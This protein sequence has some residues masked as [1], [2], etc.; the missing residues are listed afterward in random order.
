MNKGDQIYFQTKHGPKSGHVHAVGKHGA[1]VE[2]DGKRHKVKHHHVLGVKASIDRKF[3]IVDKG[4]EGSLVEDDEG[5]RSYVAGD[6]PDAEGYLDKFTSLDSVDDGDLV[7]RRIEREMHGTRCYQVLNGQ[8]PAG[9]VYVGESAKR[10]VRLLG[11]LDTAGLAAPYEVVSRSMVEGDNEKH[12]ALFA[13]TPEEGQL[14]DFVNA[15]AVFQRKNS[16][17]TEDIM[18]IDQP[19]NG[20]SEAVLSSGAISGKTILILGEREGFDERPVYVSVD[21][22]NMMK[23]RTLDNS[24]VLFMK[25]G[26]IKNRAGLSL[27]DVTDKRGVTEKRW[28]R[29]SEPVKKERNHAQDGEPGHDDSGGGKELP[30]MKRGDSVGFQAGS[31]TGS[32]EIVASGKDGVTVKD[33]RGRERKIHY[34]EITDHK[35]QSPDYSEKEDGEK[36]WDKNKI[37]NKDELA[38]GKMAKQGDVRSMEDLFVQAREALPMYKSF[39]SNIASKEGWL[40]FD[41]DYDNAV[42]AYSKP[43]SGVL[44]LIAGLKGEDRV[45]EKEKTEEDSW[46]GLKDIVRG[47]IAV[48]SLSDLPKVMDL[49]RNSGM[50]LARKPKNKFAKP[51]EHG[52]RDLN[53]NIITSNGHIA[54][55]QVNTKAM[56]LAKEDAHNHYEEIRTLEETADEEDRPLTSSESVKWKE[57]NDKSIAIY[58]KAWDSH[59]DEHSGKSS[60]KELKKAILFIVEKGGRK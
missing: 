49:L 22:E 19:V 45:I 13:F 34:D 24:V 9:S 43:D 18:V 39:V 55:L 33:E 25:S 37:F 5:N 28:K 57:L 53:L 10:A 26:P 8:L 12:G 40:I 44:L 15:V 54:E 2:S 46:A 17:D 60:Q 11:H 38:L 20:M 23:A 35:Q 7:T 14:Q 41:D 58:G 42:D 3:N 59:A 1:T 4:D 21:L 36:V 50:K 16:L 51:T 48:D 31:A 30:D 56:L 27:Q 52:Y 32:G 29:T 47:T 6:M